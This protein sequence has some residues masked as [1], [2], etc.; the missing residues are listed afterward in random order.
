M[1]KQVDQVIERIM[2]L[3]EF[4]V[5]LDVPEGFSFNGEVP[6]DMMIKNG[7]AKVRVVAATQEEATNKAHYY[8]N[9]NSRTE[10]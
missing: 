8:F 9:T 3:K 1:T 6:F 4:T 2:N 5:N 10:D 7:R